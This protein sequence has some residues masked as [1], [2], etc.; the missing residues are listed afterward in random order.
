MRQQKDWENCPFWHGG[1]KCSNYI[2]SYV[3]AT[4]IAVAFKNGKSASS[5]AIPAGLSGADKQ[6]MLKQLTV[7]L[8]LSYLQLHQIKIKVYSYGEWQFIMQWMFMRIVRGETFL[9]LGD[10]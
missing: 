9:E 1:Y 10:I 5:A 2:S 4:N 3:Y 7:F 8:G 6:N